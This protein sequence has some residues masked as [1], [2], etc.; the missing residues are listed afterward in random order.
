MSI[1]ITFPF[2][3]NSKIDAVKIRE[4][5]RAIT[6]SITKSGLIFQINSCM[7]IIS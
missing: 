4:P 7:I 5:S 1:P 2:P 6:V 3:I